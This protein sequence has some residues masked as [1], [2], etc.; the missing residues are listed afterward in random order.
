MAMVYATGRLCGAH[1][2]PA[3]TL[4]FTFTAFPPL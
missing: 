3:V 1:L 4:A 2:N